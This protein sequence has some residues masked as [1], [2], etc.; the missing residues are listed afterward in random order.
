MSGTSATPRRGPAG[1]P[2]GTPA[3]PV[4]LV[5]F[6]GI[7]VVFLVATAVTSLLVVTYYP[8]AA[9]HAESQ[10]QLS[11]SSSWTG[12]E[13]QPGGPSAGG[14]GASDGGG[15]AAN[16][17]SAAGDASGTSAASG[18]DSTSDPSYSSTAD[19][20]GDGY[21]DAMEHTCTDRLPGAD[22]GVQDVYVEVD[23]T[24]NETLDDATVERLEAAFANA[25][26]TNH[27]GESGVRL[28]VVRDDTGLPEPGA[29]DVERGPG[30]HDDVWDYR[31][32]YFDNAGD[33]YYY[34]L[35]T[36]EA[37]F[38]GDDYYAGAGANGTALVEAYDSND[39]MTSLIMHELGHAFGIPHDGPG[40]DSR[41]FD[42]DAYESVMN[43]NALYDVQTYADGEDAVGRDEWAFVAAERHVP[44]IDRPEDGTCD[45]GA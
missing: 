32:K 28:H 40:V 15:A 5:P 33:G 31:S 9:G 12:F 43:Y 23:A 7:V 1:G 4:D 37:A 35:L 22:P 38:E 8:P 42:R 30:A 39:V 44:S 27:D 20:D 6:V 13:G 10:G 16:Q 25:P 3:L 41:E 34:V 18:V 17:P 14:A 11:T 24:G 29:V 21:S 26:V 45:D 2:V 19:T 36:S